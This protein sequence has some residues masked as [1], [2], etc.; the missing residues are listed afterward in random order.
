L[1]NYKNQIQVNLVNREGDTPL[2]LGKWQFNMTDL[3]LRP[4][5][6]G[7][8][9]LFLTDLNNYYIKF[10]DYLSQNYWFDLII[11]QKVTFV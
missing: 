9:F 7:H 11:L 10:E 3:V 1:L 5:I 4:Y 6:M 2:H 8:N